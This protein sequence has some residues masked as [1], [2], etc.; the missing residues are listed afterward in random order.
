MGQKG[1][2]VSYEPGTINIVGFRNTKGRVDSYDDL[3][4]VFSYF[5]DGWHASGYAATTRPGLSY[6]LYPLL[7]KGTAILV[8][9]QYKNAWRVGLHRGK[10]PALV[11]VRPVKV[12]RDN[13]RDAEYDEVSAE[14]GL[15]GINIHRAEGVGEKVG[16]NSAGCQVLKDA[17]GY[18]EFMTRCNQVASKVGNKFSYTLLELAL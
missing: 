18:V 6:L 1:Y 17:D 8:P 5:E 14:E 3:I 16:Q 4:S 13:D 12:F 11:Q 2:D 10:Y 7:P 9:G 15:F